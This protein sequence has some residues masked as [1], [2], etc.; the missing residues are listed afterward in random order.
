MSANLPQLQRE[1]ENKVL[2]TLALKQELRTL[3]IVSSL[4]KTA[5][6]YGKRSISLLESIQAKVISCCWHV[7]LLPCLRF[8]NAYCH[9]NIQFT[10]I[11]AVQ[12]EATS[13]PVWPSNEMTAG[14]NCGKVKKRRINTIGGKIPLTWAAERLV[15]WYHWPVNCV[16]FER[17]PVP[18][19][20]RGVATARQHLCYFSMRASEIQTPESAQLSP[21]IT[22]VQLHQYLWK[23]FISRYILFQSSII[24]E[25]VSH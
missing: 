14:I 22:S 8:G 21:S 3:F 19:V 24:N 13:E 17:S 1:Q 7:I 20:T 23:L 10:P 18:G 16:L 9:Q 25:H 15:H 11:S 6:K 4:L 5:G 2:H 12:S